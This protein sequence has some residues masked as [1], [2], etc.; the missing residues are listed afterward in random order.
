MDISFTTFA[1]KN[2]NKKDSKSR[3]KCFRGPSLNY[4]NGKKS[5]G[6]G[7]KRGNMEIQ[8]ILIA[9][10]NKYFTMEKT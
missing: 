4:E 8:L 9:L 10:K 5:N 1:D 3:K 2:K 7:K 6:N